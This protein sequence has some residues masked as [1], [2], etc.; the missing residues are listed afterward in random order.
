MDVRFA[1]LHLGAAAVAAL[2][3]VASSAATVARAQPSGAGAAPGA[4]EVAAL[5][6]GIP[7]HGA[8]LG[9]PN[10]RLIVVEYAD[11]QCTYCARFA[12]DTLPTIVRTYVRTG[13]VRLVFRGLAFL[14]PDSG[15]AL[16]WTVAAGRQNRLWN[17]LDLLFLGQ[18]GENSGWVTDARLAAVA[19]SV[20][21]L[22]LARMR[23]DSG[24]KAVK[25]QIAEMAEW[26]RK[27]HVPGTPFFQA[28]GSLMSLQTVPL[29]SFDPHDFATQLD[30]LLIR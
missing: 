26:G 8:S 2:S 15:K 27:A 28:G 21:G 13:R 11:L 4:R 20:P 30:R 5:L 14:G 16:R 18:G 7:Q 23:Q 17:V 19:R 10:A 9:K 3:L 24:G 6:R 1:R 25:A 29:K 22:D 12:R